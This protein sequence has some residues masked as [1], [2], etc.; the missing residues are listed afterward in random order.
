MPPLKLGRASFHQNGVARTGFAPLLVMGAPRFR[1]GSEIPV[2]D[3]PQLC[4][5]GQGQ[6]TSST[7]ECT[8]VLG[9]LFLPSAG[10]VT[11]RAQ[12]KP[13]AGSPALRPWKSLASLQL[14]PEG[15][16]DVGTVCLV[17]RLLRLH[18]PI[19]PVNL[20]VETIRRCP[21]LNSPWRARYCISSLNPGLNL[22]SLPLSRPPVGG[23]SLPK[24]RVMGG[25][26]LVAPSCHV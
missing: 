24:L 15:E 9:P 14:L 13:S 20:V 18:Q 2:C 26:R 4:T 23:I 3:L 5:R 17:T 10:L 22:F 11:L 8:W 19:L 7:G 21:V 16:E 6:A 12:A 1:W 25:L